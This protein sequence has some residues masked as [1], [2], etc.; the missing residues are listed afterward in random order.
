MIPTPE[1]AVNP[2]SWKETAT[3]DPGDGIP[4]EK[5]S[6]FGRHIKRDAIKRGIVMDYA[7][8]SGNITIDVTSRNSDLYLRYL[9]GSVGTITIYG[10]LP[11]GNTLYIDPITGTGCNAIVG[12]VTYTLTG[13]R[14]GV[15]AFH[16][17]GNE[18]RAP[19]QTVH[20]IEVRNDLEVKGAFVLGNGFVPGTT[21]VAYSG[22][23]IPGQ[24]L[25]LPRGLIHVAQRLTSLAT[26]PLETYYA[27]V[28]TPVLMQTDIAAGAERSFHHLLYSNGSSFR[29][30]NKQASGNIGFVYFLHH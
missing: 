9:G 8:V 29:L 16:S 18:W 4:I 25:Y 12:G 24:V 28:W 17:I 26:Y 22:T 2:L 11:A 10:R 5:A 27:G 30:Y 19:S 7:E 23:L 21:R 3:F 14:R 15:V 13:A 1:F 6:G 20:N